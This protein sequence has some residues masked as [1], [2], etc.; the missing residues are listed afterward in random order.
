MLHVLCTLLPLHLASVPCERWFVRAPVRVQYYIDVVNIIKN[1]MGG[2]LPVL[3]SQ[4]A[5]LG[6]VITS[7][8]ATTLGVVCYWL[9]GR[10]NK[11]SFVK[12]R[13][14]AGFWQ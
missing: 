11:K 3:I 5:C 6:V 12:E 14:E 7:F 10:L 2:P 13:V 4:A 8:V 9:A 1:C